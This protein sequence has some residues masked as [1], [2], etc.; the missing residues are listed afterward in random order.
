MKRQLLALVLLA[1]CGPPPPPTLDRMRMDV[2]ANGPLSG[3][4]QYKTD[5][6]TGEATLVGL[7]DQGITTPE[8]VGFVVTLEPQSKDNDSS[9]S[10]S[11]QFKDC[12][13]LLTP[14][15]SSGQDVVQFT[16]LNATPQNRVYILTALK[17]GSATVDVVVTGYGGQT[18]LPV[19]VVAQP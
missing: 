3:L 14:T 4:V 11:G 17:P 18:S 8:G 1:A 15:V 2:Q 10:T 5:T 12:G 9:S 16:P 19:T 13:G 6:I 7:A